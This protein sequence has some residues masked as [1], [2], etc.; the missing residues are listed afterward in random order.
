MKKLFNYYMTVLRKLSRVASAKE[1]KGT[2]V[3][4]NKLKAAASRINVPQEF[5]PYKNYI[6]EN[7]GKKFTSDVKFTADE[8]RSVDKDIIKFFFLSLTLIFQN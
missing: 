3:F 2:Y 6:E 1:K 4:S 5:V 7:T 8:V